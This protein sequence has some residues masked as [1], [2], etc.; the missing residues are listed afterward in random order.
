MKESISASAPTGEKYGLGTTT[1]PWGRFASV[2][3]VLQIKRAMKMQQLWNRYSYALGN[4]LVYVDPTGEVVN[5]ASMSDE[6]RKTLLAQLSASTGLMLGYNT[7]TGTLQILGQITDATG[8]ATGSA[9]ARRDLTAAV[10]AAT[11]Y[12][13][14]A[15]NDSKSVNMGRWIGIHIYLD[16][17]DIAKIDTGKNASATFN[18]GIIF[19]HELKHAQGLKDPPRWMTKKLR[20][21]RGETVNHMNRIRRELGLPLRLQYAA[22]IDREGRYFIPF[23]EV[24]V[25]VPGG[26]P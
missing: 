15:R 19:M 14:I 2:D 10:E 18:A 17:S 21:L 24:P 3:P 1:P 22:K 20:Y 8:K 12:Y 13:G 25:Y 4:P 26:V 11:T 5:L 23:T 16:F 6:E 9:T 7:D